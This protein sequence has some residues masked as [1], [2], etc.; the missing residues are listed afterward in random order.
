VLLDDG[1]EAALGHPGE[2]RRGEEMTGRTFAQLL[3]EDRLIYARLLVCDACGTV[4]YY[5]D[6]ENPT[7]HFDKPTQKEMDDSRTK[8]EEQ[9]GPFSATRADDADTA[10]WHYRR[11]LGKL[12]TQRLHAI[13]CH[14]CGL[15]DLADVAE[16][17]SRQDHTVLVRCDRCVGRIA[18]LHVTGVS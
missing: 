1:T 15:Y 9:Y 11:L 2:I 16:R 13:P 14:A 7:L 3:S 17:R 4:D 8:L 6:D 18:T 10:H 5:R 12:T